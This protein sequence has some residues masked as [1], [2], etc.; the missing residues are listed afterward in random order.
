MR[1]TRSAIIFD[2]DGVIV[3]SEPRHERA[4]LEVFHE[5]GIGDRHGM[6]FPDY[7]G[8]SDEALWV[9]FIARHRPVQDLE[10]LTRIKQRRFI[11]MLRR[12]EPI[13]EGL[14][15]LV[16]KLAARFPLAVASGSVHAVIEEVLALCD[17]RRHF[18]AVSSVEDV[19]RTKPEPDVFLHAAEKL[20]TPPDQICVI[21][22]TVAGVQAA[23]AAG[24]D[25]IAITNTYPR[26]SLTEATRI[27]DSY[28]EVEALLL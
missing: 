12:E 2:L 10:E 15:E 4:F 16:R 18:Q 11:E 1:G 6:H 3:D 8:R 22:D 26:E 24:M 5:L 7:Y 23:N 25:V 17:L 13:F 27:V 9:D 21:E 19:G 28:A 14:P 20:Q